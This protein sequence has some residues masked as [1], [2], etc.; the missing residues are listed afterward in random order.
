MMSESIPTKESKHSGI[1]VTD[2]ESAQK[3]LLNSIRASK[4]QPETVEGETET[5]EAVS[6]QAMEN[7]ESV[8]NEAVETLTA[9]DLVDDNQQEQVS[10][11]R[12]YTVKID[13]KDTEV[14][15]DELLS[16]Y[17]R[18]ADY[19]R[20]SQVL[21]EQRKKM[22]EELAATQQERQQYQSQLEQ[23]KIQA[24]SKLEEFKSVDWTK[25]KEEDPME[26]AL[27]RDQYRELQENKRLV[28]EEQQNLAQKQQAE[29]QT[30]WNEE[31]AKQQEVM[32]QRL[33]EWNDP[34]K[35]PKLKQNIKSFALKKGFTEQEVD[36][37]IDARSVDVL[38]KAM[39]YENLLEAKISQKKAKVVPKVQ[40]PGAP[41]TK[42]E[43]NSEKVK[44]TRARLKRSGRVDDA[45][46][47]I[48][49]LMS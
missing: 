8:E 16:G 20:K 25:L 3:A 24:D 21:A 44:Q 29:M 11:P 7:A 42:S 12:T 19:T 38:H 17:S 2:V 22:D 32:A 31:L 13:G 4:E 33:P 36:S 9:E 41:S 30:K 14:T 46:L 45:A 35:G 27:K 39:M 28:A 1:P 48:K 43:V 18:Q 5:Q 34:E 47:A 23:F 10:E 49:S 6:E 37:L 15:E 40:R 26:Y